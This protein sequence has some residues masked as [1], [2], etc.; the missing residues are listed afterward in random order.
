MKKLASF[1]LYY[2]LVFLVSLPTSAASWTEPLPSIKSVVVVGG[3][4][5]NEYTGVWCIKALEKTAD[6][7]KKQ[8]PSLQISTLLANPEAHLA[9]KRFID[10]DLNRQ[11]SHEALH[12]MGNDNLPRTVESLRA[13]EIN[14]ILG[15][16][17]AETHSTDVIVDLHSTTSNMGVAL[18]I[19]EGD[20]LMAQAVAYVLLKCGGEKAKVRA[21]LHTHPSRDVRPNLASTARHG[22]TIEVGPV[23]NGVLRHDAV[24]RTQEALFALM[25]FFDR[26]NN[27]KEALMAEL[28]QNYPSGN[29]PCYKSAAAKKRGE[30][31]GK[32]SWPSDPENKNFPALMIH[33]DIQDRDFYPIKTGDPLF[34]EHDG[35]VIPYSGSHG[36]PVYLMFV[37]E[38][39]YYYESSGRGIAIC[40]RANFLFESGKLLIE[41]DGAKAEL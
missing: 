4:H 17:F 20:P 25:E 18:I 10:E 30:M 34:V 12:E 41:D 14:E 29:V 23:P 7:V 9:N 27:D 3:T 38:G 13:Q 26:H 15:P 40:L 35:T 1:P 2:F 24:E 5:G 28:K 36:S 33:K 6:K 22:F 19:A 32:I 21:L 11:F 8:F 39:G 37:N 16:K 31:S